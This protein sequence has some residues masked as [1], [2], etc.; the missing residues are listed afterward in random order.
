MS[1]RKYALSAALSLALLMPAAANGQL[2][3]HQ[4]EA[5]PNSQ[6]VTTAARAAATE[7]YSNPDTELAPEIKAQM[8]ELKEKFKK[9]EITKE[10]F[11]QEMKK[12]FP[13]GY[14]PHK[15]KGPHKNLSDEDKAKLQELKTKL[16]NGELD[17]EEFMKQKK[18]LF[19]KDSTEKQQ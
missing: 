9:G 4:R 11:H 15:G 8:K 17:K 19:H 18:E 2:N 3:N 5:F 16:D 7:L 12:L 6:L 13:D 1:F 14:K 10:Q